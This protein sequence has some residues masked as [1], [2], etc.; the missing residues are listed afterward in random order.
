[1]R[2]RRAIDDIYFLA[3]AQADGLHI[4]TLLLLFSLS[5]YIDY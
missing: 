1:M 5:V 4:I 2:Y 3:L